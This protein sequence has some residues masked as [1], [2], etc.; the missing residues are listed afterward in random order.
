MIGA[1][2]AELNIE[3]A[4]AGD[5]VYRLIATDMYGN[6]AHQDF[7]VTV[8]GNGI[9]D[10]VA[11]AVSNAVKT[12]DSLPIAGIAGIAVVAA[13]AAGIAA[14]KRREGKEDAR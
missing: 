4:Q 13:G 7:Y 12:G 8:K 3:D 1:T 9:A 11:E 6:T 5:Y 10:S 2:G 14:K